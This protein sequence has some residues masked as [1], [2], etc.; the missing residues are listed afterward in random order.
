MRD[1]RRKTHA[2]G[3]TLLEILV[4]VAVLALLIALIAQMTS[5]QMNTTSLSN[6]R[7]DAD[8]QARVVFDRM[9]G[10][11]AG[12]LNRPDADFY[13]QRNSEGNNDAFYFY[14]D[15]PAFS[16]GAPEDR[17]PVSLIGY[18]LNATNGLERLSRGLTWSNIPFLTYTNSPVTTDMLPIQQ[19]TLLESFKED[20]GPSTNATVIGEGIFRFEV[21]FLLKPYVKSDGTSAPAY[22]SVQPF[23]ERLPSASPAGPGHKSLNGIGLSDVQAVVVTL[24]ILDDQSR[25]VLGI[26]PT[27]SL[28]GM[29]SKLPDMGGGAPVAPVWQSVLTNDIT[30][31]GV[32]PKAGSQVR[33]YQRIFPLSR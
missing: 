32:P 30:T 15:A 17:N 20:L 25:K 21:G 9:A 7:L 13:L 4:A 19:T 33:I 23:N 5:G 22:F 16:S 6:K 24:A 3:F 18:R 1:I 10:D 14:S 29:A 27:A 26:P 8:S 31:L 11:F 12:I 2:P 28:E